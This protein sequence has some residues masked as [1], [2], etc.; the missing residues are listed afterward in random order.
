MMPVCQ[1]LLLTM[2]ESTIIVQDGRLTSD[3]SKTIS[4]DSSLHEGNHPAS[5]TTSST[6][7]FAASTNISAHHATVGNC[8][9]VSSLMKTATRKPAAVQVYEESKDFSIAL[10]LDMNKVSKIGLDIIG[11]DGVVTSLAIGREKHVLS[12]PLQTKSHFWSMKICA[13]MFVKHFQILPPL[14]IPL[15]VP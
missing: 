5:A 11:A 2:R 8:D 14:L 10:T 13:M 3:L 1:S 15:R 12:L 9:S 4:L 6:T 7:P